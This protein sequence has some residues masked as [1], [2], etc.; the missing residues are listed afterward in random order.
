MFV[1]SNPKGLALLLH[2]II[3]LFDEDLFRPM[4]SVCWFPYTMVQ[5]KEFKAIAIQIA[6]N[7]LKGRKP[8]GI[9]S[10]AVIETASGVRV[11]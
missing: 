5:L 4:F 1:K 3:C 6:Q 7:E 8:S 2:T 10:K 9:L 11:W